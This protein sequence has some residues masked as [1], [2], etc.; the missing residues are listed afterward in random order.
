MFNSVALNVVISLVF[1]YLLYSL[2]ATII[3]EVI[4]TNLGLRGKILKKGISRMLDDGTASK[5]LSKVFY[6]HPLIKYLAEKENPRSK[7][8]YL[9]AQNF[10]KVFVDLLRGEN[11]Q[12]GQDIRPLIQQALDNAETRWV[13]KISIN[14]ETLTYLRSLWADSQGDVEKFKTLL[15]QWF[16]DTMAR[17]TGWYKKQTQYILFA[18][19]F[20]LALIFN[21]DTIS[22]TKKLSSDPKL[23][24]QLADNASAYMETHQALG[25]QLRENKAKQDKRLDELMKK[26][27]ASKAD[28]TRRTLDSAKLHT[29][30]STGNYKIDST[31]RYIAKQ[32]AVLIDSA[33]AMINSEIKNVNQLLGLGWECHST[34]KC[35]CQSS[36]FCVSE[37][38][39]WW[40]LLGWF[41]T[42]LAISLGAPFWF[43]LLNKLIKMRVAGKPEGGSTKDDKAQK[44][45]AIIPK[46]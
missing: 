11:V 19:G 6:E 23:A 42:A 21:V 4:A 34:Q 24:A 18:I 43:D 2:L 14:P 32:S 45:T 12:P 30:D 16:D 9:S 33:N 3:Q 44:E 7:P 41:I 1:I 13:N 31:E 25:E 10:S 46:G 5:M 39:H 27:A 29:V 17:A 35:S 36:T 8:S 28:S 26:P 15:E 37:N 40:S 22:I 38:V 20:S